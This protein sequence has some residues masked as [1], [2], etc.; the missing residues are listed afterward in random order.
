MGRRRIALIAA[1]LAVSLPMAAQQ[2]SATGAERLEGMVMD[3]GGTP[4]GGVIVRMSGRSMSREALTNNVGGFTIEPV[5]PGVYLLS[6]AAGSIAS[7]EVRVEVREGEA[8]PHVTLTL[9]PPLPVETVTVTAARREE[10]ADAT[11]A[12]VAVLDAGEL[13]VT[14]APRLDDALRQIPGFTLFRRTSGRVANPTTQGGSLRGVGGSGAGR[15][16]VLDDGLPL[17]DPFGGWVAW[18][19]V[20]RLSVERVEV[21]R[22]GSSLYGTSAL[23]G[24]VQTVRRPGEPARLAFEAL[25]G[26]QSTTDLGLDARGAQGPWSGS[27]SGESYATDGYILTAPEDRGPIDTAAGST[28]R[29]FEATGGRRLGESGRLFARLSTFDED[30]DNG[31]PL[32]TNETAFDQAALGW[33][34]A[35]GRGALQARLYGARE[36]YEQVFSAVSADRTT[37]TLTRVQNVP[38]RAAGVSAQWTAPLTETQEILA[39]IEASRVRGNSAETVLTGSGGV[40]H[41]GGRQVDLAAFA[42]SRAA[43]SPRTRLAAG[44]RFDRFTNSGEVVDAAGNETTPP[45]TDTSAWSPRLSL[46][47]AAT[48]AVAFEG[49]AWTSFR[50]PTLNELYRSFQAGGVTTLANAAL[51]PERLKGIDAGAEFGSPDAR[52]RGAARLFWMRIDDAI[53]NVTLASDPTGNTRQRQNLARTVT[54]GLEADLEA[55]ALRRLFVGA[56]VL[57]ADATVTDAGGDATLEGAR[58]PQVPR[59]QGTIQVRYED[60]RGPRVGAQFRMSGPV[61]EDDRNTLELGNLHTLDLFAS[62]PIAGRLEVFLAGENLLNDRF[63]TGRTPVVTLGSPRTV[64]AGVRL[65]WTRLS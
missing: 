25:G 20:P 51:D 26:N 44:V 49:G 56:G 50:A 37:E 53:L 17:N 60:P 55:R 1:A 36:E 57:L 43:L 33:D 21:L 30:R 41:S 10:P 8:P 65:S 46:R 35:L 31:T 58:I 22:G 16:L 42:D 23:A 59:A 54:R 18:G 28:Q 32:Q 45:E 3:V 11:A 15:A 34:G 7:E 38:S 14:A 6:A 52:V 47:V 9:R 64:T 27:F 19:R 24:V 48:D 13:A 39:G 29:V 40:V 4:A 2:V 61:F 12:S 63:E 5:A 62:M